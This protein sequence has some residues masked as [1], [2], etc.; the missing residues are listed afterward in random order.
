MVCDIDSCPLLLNNNIRYV[1]VIPWLT[2]GADRSV[3]TGDVEAG[4]S[5][6]QRHRYDVCYA[7][8]EANKRSFSQLSSCASGDSKSSKVKREKRFSV[9]FQIHFYTCCLLSPAV[10][11]RLW[12]HSEA[13]VD[14]RTQKVVLLRLPELRP[15]TKGKHRQT[16]IT[17]HTHRLTH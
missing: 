3:S 1:Q 15:C 7:L 9:C 14:T 2:Q 13:L 16:R 12:P 4:H 5:F 11:V 6:T 10:C 17:S 8:C